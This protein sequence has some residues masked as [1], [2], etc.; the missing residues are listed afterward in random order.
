MLTDVLWTITFVDGNAFLSHSVGWHGSTL[1]H[2][3]TAM[4]LV[5]PYLTKKT[6]QETNSAD[7]KI[8]WCWCWTWNFTKKVSIKS[9]SGQKGNILN[10][11]C[12][13][14]KFLLDILKVIIRAN[15]S[16][17]PHHLLN[18][19]RP[20]VWHYGVDCQVGAYRLAG[21]ND[22]HELHDYITNI[23]HTHD[24]WCNSEFTFCYHPTE[25]R[26]CHGPPVP[27]SVKLNIV[28]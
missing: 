7:W 24:W 10:I 13:T 9:A 25:D 26:H 16:Y 28:M 18:L 23:I 6:T 12:S 4:F 1:V 19:S 27:N 21:K 2:C 17:F 3:W 14:G 22:I 8:G 20:S 15:L 11:C 5:Q